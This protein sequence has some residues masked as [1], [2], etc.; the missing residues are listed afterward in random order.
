MPRFFKS[1]YIGDERLL[2]VGGLERSSS[3]SSVK[4]Y[5]LDKGKLSAASDLAIGRQYF[6]LLFDNQDVY[7]IGGYNHEQGILEECEKLNLLSRQWTSVCELNRGRINAASCKCGSNYIYTLGGLDGEEFLDS[8]ER[9]N[10]KLDIWTEVNVRLPSPMA[11][12]FAYS[13]ND[14]HIIILGGMK[15]KN[16]EFVPKDSRK[17]YEID[18]HV[19]VLKT[20]KLK[21]KSIRSLPFKKKLSNVVH[22]GNGKF[23][24]FIVEN[25]RELPQ[26]FVYDLKQ[27][28]PEFDR[29]WAH[30]RKQKDAGRRIKGKDIQVVSKKNPERNLYTQSG[31]SVY[32]S[33][34]PSTFAASEQPK[35]KITEMTVLSKK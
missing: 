6:S 14:N 28:Y 13:L 18:N 22:N 33:V 30:E 9:Y 12:L 32:T 2:L 26:L 29:Y 7:A 3:Q 19:Y 16:M 1:V 17:M 11:N 15:K 25:N 35:I 23:F 5:I 21:F 10:S 8:I 20:E 27:C 24:C 34:N 31:K 4:S